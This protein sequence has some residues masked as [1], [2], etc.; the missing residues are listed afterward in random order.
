VG[1]HLDKYKRL[2]IESLPLSLG[3]A[4]VIGC[5]Q[6]HES[7]VRPVPSGEGVERKYAASPEQGALH[8]LHAQ[9]LAKH[10]AAWAAADTYK[11]VKKVQVNWSAPRELT[12]TE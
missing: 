8:P 7:V 12:Q 4:L 1:D 10:Q 2:W 3:L 5:A 9:S 6:S 11:S